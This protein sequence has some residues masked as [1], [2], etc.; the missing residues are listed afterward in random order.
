MSERESEVDHCEL[1]RQRPDV[2]LVKQIQCWLSAALPK[3]IKLTRTWA[4]NHFSIFHSIFTAHEELARILNGWKSKRYYKINELI[5]NVVERDWTWWRV[6][7]KMSPLNLHHID[8][9]ESKRN[10]ELRARQRTETEAPWKR[11]NEIIFF[12][13]SNKIAQSSWRVWVYKSNT[14]KK[15]MKLA[16]ACTRVR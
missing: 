4:L 9:E 7:G 11:P 1:C 12:A 6:M 14:W 15:S 3:L 16:I 2:K 13:N 5:W 10:N 8:G